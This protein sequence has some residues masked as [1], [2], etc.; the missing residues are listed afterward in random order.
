MR[1]TS[2]TDIAKRCVGKFEGAGEPIVQDIVFDSR[3]I[4][5]GDL[6]VAV[7]GENVDGHLFCKDAVAAGAVGCLVSQA[8]E[9]PHILVT[10]VVES[11]ASLGRSYR[12]RFSGPV[13]GVTGSA[14]KT[15]TKELIACALS[16]LGHVI[17]NS[18]NRN[19]EFTSPLLWMDL[20]PETKAAVVEM[21]MRGF[22]QIQHLTSISKPNIGVITN[23]GWAHVAMVGG[24]Q[25]I[26][27]AK[28]E[29]FDALPADGLACFWAEDDYATLLGAQAPCDVATFGFSAGSD[30]RI[31]DCEQG[32]AGF[33]VSGETFGKKWRAELPFFGRTMALNV[34]CA[35]MVASHLGFE[36][37]QAL[38]AL[39]NVQ[40]PPMRNQWV[41]AGKGR[42]FVDTYNSNPASTQSMIEMISGVDASRRYAV[43]GTMRELGEWSEAGHRLVG[44]AVAASRLEKVLLFGDDTHWIAD[45][46]V[47]HGFKPDRLLEVDSLDEV[48]KF[49]S[50]LDEGDVLLLKGSRALELERALGG[51]NA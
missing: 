25:G 37:D 11:L 1:P 27:K 21:G 20:K 19:S 29:L 30:S 15:T 34:A 4:K 43:L 44:S 36:P 47:K 45:E 33:V 22:G 32:E 42:V 17:S 40:L 3:S 8:V 24:R 6:Y 5:L 49:I 26:F 41:Q 31:L 28:N 2:I 12:A 23:I 13:V 35:V 48:A 9:E 38:N 39:H 51:A 16:G 14:G 50:N 10:D 7:K 18:G 46:A